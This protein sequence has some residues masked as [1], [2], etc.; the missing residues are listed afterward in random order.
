[1]ASVQLSTDAKNVLPDDY[2]FVVRK[3]GAGGEISYT[4]LQMACLSGGG[5]GDVTLSGTDG[6]SRSGTAFRAQSATNS[7]I[8]VSIDNAGTLTIG[9]FYI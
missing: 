7:N 9:A 4:A 8:S 3:G 2:E 1:M 5:G 6:S